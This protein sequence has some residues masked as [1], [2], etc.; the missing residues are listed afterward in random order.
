MA[1]FKDSFD[2]LIEEISVSKLMAFVASKIN[3][4][5]DR[6][7]KVLEIYEGDFKAAVEDNFGWL[8]K[9][10][11]ENKWVEKWA[12]DKT[13]DLKDFI[14][15]LESEKIEVVTFLDEEYPQNLTILDKP[16][17]ALYYQGDI[18]LLNS[19]RKFITVVGSRNYTKYAELALNKILKPLCLGGVGVVSGLA[20]G[21]DGL[22][23]IVALESEVPTIGVIGSGLDKDSFYP[24]LNW[25]TRCKM[26]DSGGLILSEYAPKT[27]PNVYTFPERNRILAALTDITFVVQASLKS[28]SLITADFARD[29]GKTV[30]TVPGSIFETTMGGNLKL[31]K[32]GANVATEA[33]DILSLLGLSAHG[34]LTG[35]KV[36]LGNPE[37]KQVYG[38]LSLEP[39]GVEDI[40]NECDLD[41]LKVST[42][43]TFLELSGAACNMGEN[44]WI[45]NV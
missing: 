3:L 9:K 30:V 5:C 28:G 21:I 2:G 12:G 36:E 11:K 33:E 25:K 1:L 7:N 41:V 23:H 39:K 40:A 18:D 37:E 42:V 22:S 34:S 45:R 35:Q 29:L 13:Q 24:S 17:V 31:I 26:L 10:E 6:V 15:I 27:K 38:A 19:D 32:D 4:S 8:D 16:P 43:L 44:R 14:A 20:I